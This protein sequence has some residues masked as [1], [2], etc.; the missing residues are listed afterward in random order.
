VAIEKVEVSTDGTAW[1]LC[2][3]TASWSADVNLEVGS[4]TI[5]ARVTDSYGNTHEAVVSVTVET[6]EPVGNDPSEGSSITWILLV[7]G[8]VGALVVILVFISRNRSVR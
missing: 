1:T 5:T 6:P 2:S 4:N 7:V 3:G 8:A